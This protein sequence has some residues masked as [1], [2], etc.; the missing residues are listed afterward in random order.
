MLEV[1]QAAQLLLSACYKY[2]FLQNGFSQFC[3]GEI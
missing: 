2:T 3:S 1:N